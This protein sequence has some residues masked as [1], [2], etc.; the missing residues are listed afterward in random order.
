MKEVQHPKIDAAMSD[1]KF[2]DIIAQVIGLRT[3][4]LMP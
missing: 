2:I 4:Q 1:A 3:P